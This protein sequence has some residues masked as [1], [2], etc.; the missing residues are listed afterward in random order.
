M[1]FDGVINTF[2]KRFSLS[3]RTAR[4][5]IGQPGKKPKFYNKRAMKWLNK[6]CLE[7]NAEIVVT[8][9]WRI[10]RSVTELAEIL[11]RSGLDKRICVVGRTDRFGRRDAEI[12]LW[13]REHMGVGR[14]VV[15]DDDIFDLTEVADHLVL[16]DTY[17]GLDERCYR[18][19]MEIMKKIF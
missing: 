19:A 3:K 15:L 16:V 4:Y 12:K 10:R 7:S 18:E 17:D 1:I 13:L 5:R 8:S 11:Y 6:I 14:F 9:T 2:V